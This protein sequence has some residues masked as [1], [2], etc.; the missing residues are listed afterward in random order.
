MNWRSKIQKN[1]GGY[2]LEVETQRE[3][4]KN[5]YVG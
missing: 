1:F 4:T 3:G 2:N 5:S